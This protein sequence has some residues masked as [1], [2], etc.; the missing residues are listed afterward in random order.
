MILGLRGYI[1][2]APAKG[3][4]KRRLAAIVAAG[5]L[6]PSHGL[7]SLCAR[8]QQADKLPRVGVISIAPLTSP[9]YQAFLQGLHDLGYVDGKNIAII[10]RSA[11][12][13]PDR[14]PEL[15]RELVHLN[16]NVLLVGGD[17]AL[18]AAK[19]ATSRIPIILEACD[20][21]DTLVVSLAR[22]EERQR[23]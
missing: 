2:A 18:R 22:P 8:A 7:L 17:Q 6:L 21:I 23:A 15:A 13:N 19:E 1:M 9:H 11:E 16:V 12:G 5:V 3:R 14:Y 4:V 10:A 20:P